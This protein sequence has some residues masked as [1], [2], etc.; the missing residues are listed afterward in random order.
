MKERF[1]GQHLHIIGAFAFSGSPLGPVALRYAPA[2]LG[3]VPKLH[4]E[5]AKTV[6]T[7][8]GV[9]LSARHRR[10]IGE[11]YRDVLSWGKERLT[12]ENF[13]REMAEAQALLKERMPKLK[14]SAKASAVQIAANYGLIVALNA[15][16]HKHGIDPGV[17]K[18]TPVHATLLHQGMTTAVFL[19]ELAAAKKQLRAGVVPASAQGAVPIAAVLDGEKG[20]KRW[21]VLSW[22]IDVAKNAAPGGGGGNPVWKNLPGLGVRL[23]VALMNYAHP[24]WSHRVVGSFSRMGE[25]FRGKKKTEKA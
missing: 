22:A 2:E 5:L 25:K 15:L 6:E 3:G 1:Q 12:R 14:E 10:N 9:Q 7:Q 19:A 18:L 11:V 17:L 13:N 23:G 16:L 8:S 20:A 4:E 24:D 21:T